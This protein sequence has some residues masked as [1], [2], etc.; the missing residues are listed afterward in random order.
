MSCALRRACMGPPSDIGLIRPWYRVQCK[1]YRVRAQ[2]SEYR[3]I[4]LVHIAY[5]QKV[6]WF[7][8]LYRVQAI[9]WFSRYMQRVWEA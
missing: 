7:S 9:T 4:E 8:V 6:Q 2:L 1:K 3:D 5:N